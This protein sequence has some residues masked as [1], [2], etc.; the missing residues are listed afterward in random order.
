[1]GMTSP[2]QGDVL[3]KRNKPRLNNDGDYGMSYENGHS[4]PGIVN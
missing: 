2:Q 3:M 4:T 1:M